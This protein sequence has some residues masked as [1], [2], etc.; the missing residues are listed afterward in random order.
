MEVTGSWEKMGNKGLRDFQ[1]R[2]DIVR[3]IKLRMLGW[4]G[5]IAYM[6]KMGNALNVLPGNPERTVL[7]GIHRRKDNIKMNLK[8]RNGKT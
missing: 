5:Y 2:P 8:K 3:V 1:G 4:T 6:G 7:L